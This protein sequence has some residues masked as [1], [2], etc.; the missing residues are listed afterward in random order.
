VRALAFA[1]VLIVACG[2]VGTLP[3]TGPSAPPESVTFMAGFKPQANLPFVAVYLAQERGYFRAQNLDV[4][5]EHSAGQGEHVRLLGTGRIHFS[6]GSAQDVLK[7]VADADV[8]LVA[9]ALIGQRGEQAFAVRADSGI[10][11]P[12]DWEGRLVGYKGVPSADYL[13]L[14]R[15]AGVDRGRVR[16]VSVGF[17]PRVLVARQVD[18]YPVFISNEPYTLERLGVGVRLFEAR[19]FGVPT[20]GLTFM[21]NRDMAENRP[22]VVRRFLRAALRGLQDAATDREAALDAVMKY[23]PG[24]ARDHMRFMLEAELRNA[25]SDLTDRNGLGWMTHQQWDSLQRV[26]VDVG[27]QTRSVDVDG[28]QTDRFLRDL[29]RDGRLIWP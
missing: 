13:A 26:L 23:A 8:P 9:I 12:K 4:Q 20:L 18:V 14:L 5:I 7:R 1:C 16:E 22:E 27:S 6:T 29:Y 24:E 15:A 11:G 10:S 21:T 25:R 2:P 3:G 19:D 17:D 28:V